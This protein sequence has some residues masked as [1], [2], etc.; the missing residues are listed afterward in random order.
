M[1]NNIN[2]LLS[3]CQIGRAES[4]LQNLLNFLTRGSDLQNLH[5][6][7]GKRGHTL[8]AEKTI[9]LTKA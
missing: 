8:S 6:L 4:D 7:M 3:K 2:S 5:S 9:K 1:K